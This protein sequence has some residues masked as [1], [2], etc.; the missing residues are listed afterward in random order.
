M[1]PKKELW[2]QFEHG[3]MTGSEDIYTSIQNYLHHKDKLE[4]E[5]PDGPTKKDVENFRRVM[6]FEARKRKREKELAAMV[7]P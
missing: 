1:L 5:E 2:G 7:K 4:A 3:L 6:N